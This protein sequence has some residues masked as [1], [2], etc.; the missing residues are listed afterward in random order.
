[1]L[2]ETQRDPLLAVH[3]DS[4]RS[5]EYRR[6]DDS[7]T[8]RDQDVA[9]MT[10]VFQDRPPRGRGPPR[11]LEAGARDDF[12]KGTNGEL[13]ASRDLFYGDVSPSKAAD[14]ARG[15]GRHVANVVGAQ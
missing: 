3:R 13:E 4:G 15:G 14:V 11:D 2:V 12:S 6:G 10:A 5:V 7:L 1:M 9:H 8:N